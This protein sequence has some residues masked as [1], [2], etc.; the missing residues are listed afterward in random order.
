MVEECP[1]L[2][3]W[4]PRRAQ[5]AKWREALGEWAKRKKKEEAEQEFTY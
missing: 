4:R 3:Q 5:W 2:E 1:E